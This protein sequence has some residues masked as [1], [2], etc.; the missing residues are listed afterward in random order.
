[1]NLI[2]LQARAPSSNDLNGRGPLLL[3]DVLKDFEGFAPAAKDF[4]WLIKSK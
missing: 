4:L 2:F 1:M 3:H